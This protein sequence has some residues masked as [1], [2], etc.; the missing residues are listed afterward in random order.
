MPLGKLVAITT[1]NNIK[2]KIQPFPTNLHL[3]YNES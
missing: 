3:F 2:K 1:L